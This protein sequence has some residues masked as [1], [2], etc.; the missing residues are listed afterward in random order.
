VSVNVW[1]EFALFTRPELKVERV[2]YPLMT[3]SAARG[4]PD[5]ILWKPQMRW[6]VRRV[7]ALRPTFPAGFP[8][9]EAR[10]PYRLVAIRRNEVTDKISTAKAAG[11][12]SSPS[13][14][15]PY[16]VDENRTQRNSLL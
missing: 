11:W 13:R 2:S 15:E 10:E 3:P 12:S 9:D 5:A 8:A 1:G 4:V 16:R 14:R 6:H 7:M